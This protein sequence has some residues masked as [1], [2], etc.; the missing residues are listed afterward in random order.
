MKNNL[1]NIMFEKN[2]WLIDK[3]IEKYFKEYKDRDDLFQVGA[4]SLL[5]SIEKFD[6]NIS[7]NFK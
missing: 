7:K 4:I 3:C 2:I 1:R 5:E 6:S